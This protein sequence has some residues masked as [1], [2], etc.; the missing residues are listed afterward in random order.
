MWHC[1]SLHFLW[2]CMMTWVC[3][4][5][6][7]NFQ[8]EFFSGF[9]FPIE[10]PLQKRVA[11]PLTLIFKHVNSSFS[12]AFILLC[13]KREKLV[14]CHQ[15]V[16]LPELPFTIGKL[17]PIPESLPLCNKPTYAGWQELLQALCH[18]NWIG[19][20]GFVAYILEYE[21]TGCQVFTFHPFM[22]LIQPH[23]H[24]GLWYSW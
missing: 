15:P 6:R 24:E 10:T 13:Q 1:L 22:T 3:R 20:C 8:L 11:N 7:Q 12:M 4:V 19:F 5:C 18:M 2:A 21:T 23:A 9:F 17:S 14:I 16:L